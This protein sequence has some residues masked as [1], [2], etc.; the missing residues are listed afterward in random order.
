MKVGSGIHLTYC[1][2][3]HPAE[4]WPD[5]RAALGHAMPRVRDA[6][7]TTEAIAI[8]LR[9]S[10][11]AA[12]ALEQPEALASFQ[13]F[14]ATGRYYVPTING[15][16][17]GAFH[18]TRVKARVYEP[19]WRDQRRIDYTN[20]LARLLSALT[21]PSWECWGSISTVPGAFKAAIRSESDLE[22][23]ASG[24]L[25]HAAVLR[26]LAMRTGT[27]IALAI[28]P[29]PACVLETTTD[30]LAFISKFL[31]DAGAIRRASDSVGLPLSESDVR[32][33]V[34]LCLDACHMAVEY[35]DPHTA[36]TAIRSAGIRICKLQASAAA[37]LDAQ[38]VDELE[39]A[40]GPLAEDTYLHQVVERGV[41]GLQSHVDLPD[42][43]A[44]A[45]RVPS[46]PR[47]WRVHF[48]VPIFLSSLGVLR[49]TQPY[50]A[51]LL[52]L[53]SNDQE[54]PCVEVET[55][56]WS[57]LPPEHRTVEMT[58]AIA[59]ELAWARAQLDR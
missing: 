13:E 46:Q 24:M 31:F 58:T 1:S 25:R 38:S 48:H 37:E 35:E 29:E 16:P 18:G 4:T 54:C 26:D 30:A 8:G 32:Q 7:G 9:L 45:R 33:H 53:L 44:Q 22:A 56:T 23:I 20:R 17:Y 34:G 41:N 47:Q 19:D 2:N 12:E 21:G 40:F 27:P 14:L 43:L 36:L 11:A 6:L 50:L 57:V 5:V 49:T 52:A 10:A 28:E 51:S 39:T 59:R 15:F 55:Y 3:I 42:A